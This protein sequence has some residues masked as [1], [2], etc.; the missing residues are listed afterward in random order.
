MQ[1]RQIVANMSPKGWVKIGVGAAA[2]I[3]FLFFMMHMVSAPSYSTLMT[4]L[5]PAQ[6]GKITST[7]DTKGIGYQ[8]QN[9]GTALAVDSNKTSQARVA[10]ATGGLLGSQQPG[11]S[12]FDKQQLGSSNF[13]QQVT[14]QRALE[15]QLA[16]TIEGIQGVSSAQVQI[17]LPNPQDQLFSAR[18]SRRRP[19]CCC[20]APPRSTPLGP[21]YRPARRL[22]RPRVAD[23]QGHDHRRQRTAAVADRGHGAPAARCAPSRPQRPATTR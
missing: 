21:R 20:P 13:Q 2:V 12:L 4:G 23:W 18:P 19:P 1:A 16:Q 8:L 3:V 15:G 17:V 6:T 5:D 9:D 7:L 22:E 14:Y 11:F 10:L